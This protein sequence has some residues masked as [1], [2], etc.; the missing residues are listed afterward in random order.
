MARFKLIFFTLNNNYTFLEQS[1]SGTSRHHHYSPSTFDYDQP[2]SSK[3]SLSVDSKKTAVAATAVTSSY[4][5]SLNQSSQKNLTSQSYSLHLAN[6][7][8]YNNSNNETYI[9]FKFYKVLILS[10][11]FRLPITSYF[12]FSN[13]QQQDIISQKTF[14]NTET[15]NSVTL[16]NNQEKISLSDHLAGS[17]LLTSPIPTEPKFFDDSTYPELS[18]PHDIYQEILHECEP[19]LEFFVRSFVI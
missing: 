11:F 1:T 16:K 6:Q 18:S 19:M 7:Q 4:N 2:C 13:Q 14:D 5:S 15:I 3:T 8:T 12:N 10:Y 17:L 9:L